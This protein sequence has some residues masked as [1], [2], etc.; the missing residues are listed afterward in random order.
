L[1]AARV[2]PFRVNETSHLLG[3]KV[4]RLFINEGNEAQ[5][6]TG[7]FPGEAASQREQRRYSA[8]IVVRARRA[9][10]RILMRAD[11]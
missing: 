3:L 11:H 8:G 5:G 4:G 7:R 1:I 10:D 6:L 9:E 2:A